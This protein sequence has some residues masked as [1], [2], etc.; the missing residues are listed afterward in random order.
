MSV[1]AAITGI[2]RMAAEWAGEIPVPRPTAVGV[3]LSATVCAVAWY[4]AG[5]LLGALIGGVAL[6]GGYTFASAACRPGA[7]NRWWGVCL[8]GEAAVY[9]GIAAGAPAADQAWPLATG[10]LVLIAARQCARGLTGMVALPGAGRTALIVMLT[11]A[12][13]ARLTFIAL[14]GSGAFAFLVAL[15]HWLPSARPGQGRAGSGRGSGDP[16]AGRGDG[17]IARWAGRFTRGQMPPLPPALAGVAATGLLAATGMSAL[18]SALLLAPVAA[19]LLAAPGAGHPHDGRFDA[20]AGPVL[21]AGEYIYVAALGFA[22]GVAGWLTFAT[23]CVLSLRHLT[24]HQPGLTVLGWEG[25]ILLAG[26]SAL[27]GLI[28]FAYLAV[29]AYLG[30]LLVWAALSGWLSARQPQSLATAE[31]ESP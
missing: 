13:G 18:P 22:L 7:Q 2:P 14:I 11:P 19:M 29:T 30:L 24:I 16:V 5:T 1:V 4:S 20:W 27:A 17:V 23:V 26:L 28:A 9:A 25:R 6:I 31:G 15:A 21:R 8:A 12:G 10:A 3:A